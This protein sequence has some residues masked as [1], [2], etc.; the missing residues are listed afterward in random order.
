MRCK[1]VRMWM[2]AG[3]GEP[4]PAIIQHIADCP[5]C[6]RVAQA[7][8]LLRQLLSSLTQDELVAPLAV[9]RQRVGEVAGK[10]SVMEKIMLR[11]KDQITQR[12]R[13]LAGATMAVVAFLFV[14]LVPFSFTHTAGYIVSVEDTATTE[15][16]TV[17]D[18]EKAIEAAEVSD[19]SLVVTRAGDINTYTISELPNL[20]VAN[21]VAVAIRKSV[22]RAIELHVEPNIKVMS[23]PIYAQVVRRVVTEKEKEKPHR[24]KLAL[25]KMIIGE[26]VIFE[27]IDDFELKDVEVEKI[28]KE[29]LIEQGA[30]ADAI[31]V[32]SETDA[33]SNTRTIRLEVDSTV[34]GDSESEMAF[35]IVD[36]AD[37]YRFREYAIKTRTSNAVEIDSLGN[38]FIK[39]HTIILKFSLKDRDQ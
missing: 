10:Q 4:S 23:G 36:E 6:A 34:V 19:V 8:H 3:D 21:R 16:V 14:T 30:S 24:I 1:E 31:K 2:N 7:D 37:G 26:K 38:K 27:A 25:G 11:I 5:S 15:K 29:R 33:D 9:Y 39:G 32:T 18:V 28:I 22:D 13:L 35:F 12:P 17:E 20:K